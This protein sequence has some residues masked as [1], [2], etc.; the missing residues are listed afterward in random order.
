MIWIK[1]HTAR[2]RE[3]LSIGDAR[4]LTYASLEA[5]LALE[6]VCYERLRISHEY[7]SPSDLRKWRPQYVVE[8]VI[9]TVDE[10]IASGFKLSVRAEDSQEYVEVGTQIGFDPR[11]INRYWQAMSSFLH[12]ELPRNSKEYTTHYRPA[13]RMREKIEEVLAE[14][15]RLSEGTLVA[16]VVLDAVSFTCVCG[17]K[18]KRSARM[19]K[20]DSYINCISE[21]CKEQYRVEIEGGSTSFERRKIFLTCHHCKMTASFPYRPLAEMPH[22]TIGGFKCVDCGTDNA[23]QWRVMQVKKK[24]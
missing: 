12:C 3:L 4:S 19:L 17:Q 23:F 2:I 21:N 15:E 6:R 18:N 8:T 14:L 10:K 16:S 11:Q 7:I 9:A 20:H 1:D 22:D 24:E 13:N 5:R